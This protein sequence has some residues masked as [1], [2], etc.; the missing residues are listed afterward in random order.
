[1][2]DDVSRRG[3]SIVK[4]ADYMDAITPNDG[5]DL[6]NEALGLY[7]ETGGDLHI[8]TVGGSEQTVAV[9]DFQFLPLHVKKVFATGTTATGI[10]GLR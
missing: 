3:R 4:Q 2:T 8:T 5:A 6:A 7:V 10:Y 1:M 9:T